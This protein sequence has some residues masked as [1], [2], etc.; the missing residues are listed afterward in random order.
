MRTI[1]AK[2][3]QLG[4]DTEKVG[5]RNGVHCWEHGVLVYW[6]T[7]MVLIKV[8]RWEEAEPSCLLP[9]EYP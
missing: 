3:E 4:A 6:C 1:Q 2:Q 7:W 8:E 5:K 9:T